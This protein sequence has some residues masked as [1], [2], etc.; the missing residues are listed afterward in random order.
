MVFVVGARLSFTSAA[1]RNNTATNVQTYVTA[2]LAGDLFTPAIIGSYDGA[3]KGWPNALN[4]ELRLFT[5]ANR[6]ALWAQ[7]DT[8]FGTGVNGPVPGAEAWMFDSNADN[9]SL[10]QSVTY[11]KRVF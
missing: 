2:N 6:D 10:D 3:Y 11:T 1:R 5:K 8:L 7:L 4:V 9:A